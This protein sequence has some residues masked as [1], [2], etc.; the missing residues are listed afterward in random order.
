[1][2]ERQRVVRLQVAGAGMAPKVASVF[3]VD[4]AL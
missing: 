3:E 4:G 2:F 1:M